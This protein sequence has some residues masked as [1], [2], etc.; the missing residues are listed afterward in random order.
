M[1]KIVQAGWGRTG[2]TTLYEALN[3]LKSENHL[4]GAVM[5]GIFPICKQCP[6]WVDFATGKKKADKE[7]L[8]SMYGDESSNSV[9]ALLDNPYCEYYKDVLHAYPNC[10]VILLLHPGGLEKRIESFK[11][12][13]GLVNFSCYLCSHV[14]FRPLSFLLSQLMIYYF[15][16]KPQRYDFEDYKQFL[17]EATEDTFMEHSKAFVL[18]KKHVEGNTVEAMKREIAE[19]KQ[20]VPKD[21][22]LVYTVTKGWGPLCKFLGVPVPDISYPII[23]L[24]KSGNERKIFVVLQIVAVLSVLIFVSCLYLVMRVL[25]GFDWELPVLILG[26]LLSLVLCLKSMI[27]PK[28]KSG[29]LPQTCVAD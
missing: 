10:K 1:V 3:V 19:I 13:V 27:T 24:H 9:L 8:H 28:S 6:T 26:I 25:Y 14:I 15:I 17:N 22:L 7:L 12:H 18:D 16:I 29:V 20:V 23:D 5:H 11:V 21:Q 4:K 2:T